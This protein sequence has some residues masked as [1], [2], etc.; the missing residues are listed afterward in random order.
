LHESA[1]SH[2]TLPVKQPQ[3]GVAEMFKYLIAWLLGVPGIILVLIFLFS[4]VL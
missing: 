4:R 3:A 1:S 2:I